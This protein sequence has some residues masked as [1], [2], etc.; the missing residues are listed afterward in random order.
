MDVNQAI[1]ERRS[2]RAYEDK[3]IPEDVLNKLL[4]A[5]RLAPSAANR[6]Q[7]KFIVVKDKTRRKE[8]ARA[9]REQAFV[10][11][12]PVVI[13]AVSLD[14][15]YIMGCDVPE[16]AVDL[17]IAIDH[18]TL[19]AVELGLG[20]CWIGA[21]SQEEVKK[22]LNIPPQYKVVALL[23]IGYPADSPVPKSRKSIKEIVCYETFK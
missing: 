8:L 3:E 10:G 15:G 23:P 1:K 12:A 7:W 20:S 16:Y 5:A 18:I 4:E 9:S 19:Q 21:F 13:A 11:G 22:I 6:Q 17:S 2:V 14:P